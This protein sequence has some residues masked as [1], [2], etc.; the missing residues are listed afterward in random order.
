MDLSSGRLSRTLFVVRWPQSLLL[1]RLALEKS[2]AWWRDDVSM[3]MFVGFVGKAKGMGERA[4]TVPQL[5]TERGE[6]SSEE[7]RLRLM[8]IVFCGIVDGG[9]A[10]GECELWTVDC[11][12]M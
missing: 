8:V 7:E 5:E 2:Q 3:S 9:Y 12:V 11:M 4:D 10:V 6:S 1:T